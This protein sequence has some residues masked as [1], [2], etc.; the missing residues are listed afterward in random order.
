MAVVIADE[1]EWRDGEVEGGS[2]DNTVQ[3]NPALRPVA[4]ARMSIRLGAQGLTITCCHIETKMIIKM[5][6]SSHWP[7]SSVG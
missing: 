6:Y 7:T 3:T 4:R 1:T 5:E 2:R